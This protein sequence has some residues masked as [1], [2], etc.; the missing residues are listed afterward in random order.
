[1][2]IEGRLLR[3]WRKKLGFSPQEAAAFLGISER[4]LVAYEDGRK[5]VPRIVLLAARAV[6]RGLEPLQAPVPG[7]RDLWVRLIDDMTR[8]AKGE[9]VVGEILKARDRDRLNAFLQMVRSGPEPSLALTDPALFST[10]Q[11]AC[12]RAFLLGVG[13]YRQSPLTNDP[14]NKLSGN[15]SEAAS[16]PIVAARTPM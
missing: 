15:T 2:T 5:K 1:M 11:E 8:Y 16:G 4:A 6:E 10:L 12:T 7:A 13:Q 3:V 14:E 9:P